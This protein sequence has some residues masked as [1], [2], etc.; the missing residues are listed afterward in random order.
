[1]DKDQEVTSAGQHEFLLFLVA[2]YEDDMLSVLLKLVYHFLDSMS[3]TSRRTVF[4]TSNWTW[5]WQKC[6]HIST[7]VCTVCTHRSMYSMYCS[8]YCQDFVYVFFTLPQINVYV[9]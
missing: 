8:E 9:Y 7:A 6:T 1:M 4:Y 2:L 3:T 5:L